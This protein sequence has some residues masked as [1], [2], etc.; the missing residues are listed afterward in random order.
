MFGSLHASRVLGAPALRRA[1]VAPGRLLTPAA[2]SFSVGIKILEEKGHAAENRY[3][4]QE[5]EKLLRKMI[6]S[7]SEL[8]PK[9]AGVAGIL[10]DSSCST[11]DKVKL[12][13]MKHGIPPLNK[14]LIA[15]MVELLDKK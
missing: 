2:R 15:D 5:D 6:E 1:T 4:H 13:F 7:H 10:S 9:F 12:V 14:A 3:W 8:D 11:Q